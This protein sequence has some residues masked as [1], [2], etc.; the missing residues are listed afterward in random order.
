MPKTK[1][2]AFTLIEL[3]VV[4]SIIALLASIGAASL[5]STRAKARD[6]KRRADVRSIALALELYYDANGQYPR[7][8]DVTC[9]GLAGYNTSSYVS[10]TGTC[11][12][13]FIAVLAPYLSVAPKDPL[14]IGTEV[15][16]N[17]SFAY[18]Y[19]NVID[20][21]GYAIDP[22]KWSGP[23][24]YDLITKL[25]NKNDPD[26]CEL[27]QYRMNAYA[28]NQSWCGS[29]IPGA[30]KIYIYDASPSL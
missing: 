16:N 18:T 4:V 24:Q 15:Y 2:R 26:R 14:N 6:A 1:K 5:N 29:L 10:S 30:D 25:E 23:P 8:P 21:N 7:V 22:P 28:F 11:W 20:G 12:N 19:G 9:T 17:G 27:K 3:L 13:A